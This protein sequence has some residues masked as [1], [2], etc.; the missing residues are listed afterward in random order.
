RPEFAL[1]IELK[2]LF[3]I[4]LEILEKETT[5]DKLITKINLISS[6]KPSLTDV[7][8]Y[9]IIQDNENNI[10]YKDKETISI[11]IQKEFIKEFDISTLKEGEYTL[12]INVDYIDKKEPVYIEKSFVLT[13]KGIEIKEISSYKKTLFYI[14]T[15]IMLITI[16]FIYYNKNFKKKKIQYYL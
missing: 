15:I 16:C 2:E 13:K 5:Q 6:G 9:Y 1:P 4:N 10:I 7:T 12:I 8:L 11:N 3:S 14:I